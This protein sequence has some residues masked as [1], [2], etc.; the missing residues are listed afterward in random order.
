MSTRRSP[1]PM[2]RSPPPLPAGLLIHTEWP[3][4]ALESS[5]LLPRYDVTG[6]RRGALIVSS[7]TLDV[8]GRIGGGSWAA[9]MGGVGALTYP[10]MSDDER[11]VRLDTVDELTRFHRV[12]ATHDAIAWAGDEEMSVADL[13]GLKFRLGDRLTHPSE[14]AERLVNAALDR[15]HP[16]P[17]T[18]CRSRLDVQGAYPD[19]ILPS[20]RSD[21]C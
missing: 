4:A 8:V 2:S 12:L 15:A 17:P 19:S 16:P 11:P 18:P 1:P 14:D 7:D 6:Q 5:L 13:E 3:L 21:L 10:E 20:T 9:S